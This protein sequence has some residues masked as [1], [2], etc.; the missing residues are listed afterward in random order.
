MDYPPLSVTLYAF[1][2]TVCPPFAE[3][4]N[5][6]SK[7]VR[8]VVSTAPAGPIDTVTRIVSGRLAEQIG[9]QVVVDNRPGAGGSVGAELVARSPADGYNLLMGA[10][11][12]IAI[13]PNF[14]KL[15][16][17]AERDLTPI[18]LV[19]TSPLALVVHPSL[20]AKT[21][22]LTVSQVFADVS[23]TAVRTPI[24]ALDESNAELM[25]QCRER[26]GNV[27]LRARGSR[28]GG[29]LREEQALGVR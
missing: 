7:P 5:Y 25:A 14:L 21:V 13:A 4:Q 11:G 27:A 16:Y 23:M 15:P 9:Q 22:N 18:S 8:F 3:A 29:N 12:P 26:V 28:V 1:F 10:S 20:P 2:I 6:P 17:N 24:E 19:G